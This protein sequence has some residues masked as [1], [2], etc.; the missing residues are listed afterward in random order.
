MTDQLKRPL[1][2][3]AVGIILFSSPWRD[4]I[5]AYGYPRHCYLDRSE[6]AHSVEK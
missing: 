6:F 2:T 5:E 1:I 4:L 3:Y